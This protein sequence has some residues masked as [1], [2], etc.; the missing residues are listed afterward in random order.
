MEHEYKFQP[1]NVHTQIHLRIIQQVRGPP[2][3]FRG[4]NFQGEKTK[5]PPKR[6][7]NLGMFIVKL[8]KLE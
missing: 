5:V 8:R 4:M 7:N 3:V 6:C 2:F 1:G